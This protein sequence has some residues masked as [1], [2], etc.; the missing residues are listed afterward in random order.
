MTVSCLVIRPV[1]SERQHNQLAFLR[2]PECWAL[3]WPLL[4]WVGQPTSCVWGERSSVSLRKSLYLWTSA[5]A[6][7]KQTQK[8]GSMRTRKEKAGDIKEWHIQSVP[9][10]FLQPGC[11]ALGKAWPRTGW[12]T[13]GNERKSRGSVRDASYIADVER[14]SRAMW[15]LFNSQR[16]EPVSNLRINCEC[17]NIMSKSHTF[18]SVPFL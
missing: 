13:T 3:A 14:P 4:R 10:G 16:R 7:Q 6:P 1:D 15:S 2:P 5:P 18:F 11:R 17:R 9:W 12:K 8:W